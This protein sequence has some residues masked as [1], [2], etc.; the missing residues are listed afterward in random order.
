MASSTLDNVD[1]NNISVEQIATLLR[2]RRLS[3]Q[4]HIGSFVMSADS[5][6]L[7]GSVL[8]GKLG[9]KCHDS[10]VSQLHLMEYRKGWFAMEAL[11]TYFLNTLSTTLSDNTWDAI[12]SRILAKYHEAAGV[13]PLARSPSPLQPKRKRTRT[14]LSVASVAGAIVTAADAR[15]CSEV[16]GSRRSDI[17]EVVSSL[18]EPCRSLVDKTSGN[19]LHDQSA[20]VRK[21]DNLTNTLQE[22]NQEI[23]KLKY[24]LKKTSQ[25]LA[26]RDAK[27][28]ATKKQAKD[29]MRKQT[30]SLAIARSVTSRKPGVST[31]NLTIDGAVALGVRRNLGARSCADMGVAC[32]EKASRQ[33]VARAE[34]TAADLYV[35]HAHQQNHQLRSSRNRMGQLSSAIICDHCIA[36]RRN[37]FW[38]MA[39]P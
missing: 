13:F 29:A 10:V 2:I 28:V 4:P 34:L 17:V 9:K 39:T 36:Q 21:L 22:R 30:T 19:N 12:T 14:S 31:R 7:V 5:M 35:L 27:I 11:R 24:E 25:R 8:G 18:C 16:S 32:L 15:N 20:I 3:G 1:I 6:Q 33:T 23:S 38:Y 26:R 37:K